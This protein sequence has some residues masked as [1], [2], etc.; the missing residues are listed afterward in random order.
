L[1]QTR[2]RTSL[3]GR[4][5]KTALLGTRIAKSIVDSQLGTCALGQTADHPIASL[6]IL[7]MQPLD[8]L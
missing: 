3:I 4:R 1:A 8:L 7:L 5:V 6:Q 2:D